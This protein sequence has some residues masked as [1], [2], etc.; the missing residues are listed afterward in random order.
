MAEA[1]EF[2]AE[3]VR[4]IDG[5]SIIVKNEDGKYPIRIKYVDAP[6]IQ[7]KHGKESKDFLSKLIS[8]KLVFISLPYKD[9]YSRYLSDVYI[10]DDEIAIYINAKL[11]KSG[12]AWGI[13]H[14][15]QMNI[16]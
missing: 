2:K 8:G 10:Y 4:V 6:E 5:D 13:S 14:I 16:L 9:R 11:I 3:V 1:V 15:V 12:N 7:Q